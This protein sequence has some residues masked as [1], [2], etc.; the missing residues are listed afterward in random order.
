M[1]CWYDT[2]TITPPERLAR[3]L[4]QKHRQEIAGGKIRLGRRYFRRTCVSEQLIADALTSLAQFQAAYSWE[5]IKPT[6]G[7]SP[8]SAIIRSRAN[9][10]ATRGPAAAKGLPKTARKGSNTVVTY[11]YIQNPRELRRPVIN[12]HPYPAHRPTTSVSRKFC[13]SQSLALIQVLRALAAT[14]PYD[15]RN[16]VAIARPGK[17]NYLQGCLAPEGIGRRIRYVVIAIALAA[18]SF[19]AP[20]GGDWRFPYSSGVIV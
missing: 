5:C 9:R 1:P 20:V 11:T 6:G 17:P 14:S 2:H 10:R 18:L 15:C 3:L 16:E 8:P 12:H 7:C 13:I 19:D 4:I